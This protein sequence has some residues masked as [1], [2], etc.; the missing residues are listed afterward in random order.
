MMP[1][2]LRIEPEFLLQLPH[3]I[4]SAFFVVADE[5]DFSGVGFEEAS[6]D[7]EPV[8]GFSRLSMGCLLR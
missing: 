2:H 5:N 1:F 7:I 3:G 6:C 8:D 4:V